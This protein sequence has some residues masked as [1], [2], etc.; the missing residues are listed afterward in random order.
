MRGLLLAFVA[1]GFLS[2]AAASALEGEHPS[3]PPLHSGDAAEDNTGVKFLTDDNYRTELAGHNLSLVMFIVPGVKKCE[4][5]LPQFHRAAELIRKDLSLGAFLVNCAENTFLCRTMYQVD[6]WPT[7][8]IFAGGERYAAS[9]TG[10]VF[11]DDY[12][13]RFSAEAFA[14][15]LFAR[16]DGKFI[17][18]QVKSTPKT[19]RAVEK[20]Q[21]KAGLPP[22]PEGLAA[23]YRDLFFFVKN[24][25]WPGQLAA[26]A[27]V[28]INVVFLL[29]GP[30]LCPEAVDGYLDGCFLVCCF[31][32]VRASNKQAARQSY[33]DEDWADLSD[34][35][36]SADSTSTP[37]KNAHVAA[38]HGNAA[39]ATLQRR[40]P[41][42]T[43][44][45]E[46][47]SVA[48]KPQR[49]K[50]IAK[51]AAAKRKPKGE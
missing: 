38:Q 16:R 34:D 15:S 5:T 10:F 7:T 1:V 11:L 32:C 24:L 27:F 36:F 29:A 43:P 9:R 35:M 48:S 14:Y 28:W 19:K 22:P 45:A 33:D 50:R 31:C 40:R 41:R 3:T 8:K 51:T 37:P 42:P 21:A 49:G 25:G 4:D 26:L 6:T 44:A 2:V 47:T 23:V 46:A 12:E 13:G 18:D 17:M 20:K 30:F 39:T